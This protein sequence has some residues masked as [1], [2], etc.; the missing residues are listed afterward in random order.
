MLEHKVILE[1]KR[2][3]LTFDNDLRQR[4][5]GSEVYQKAVTVAVK[6]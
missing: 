1:I 3:N 4:I 6:S 5:I 2:C